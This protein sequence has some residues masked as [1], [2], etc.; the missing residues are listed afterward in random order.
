MPY[1]ILVV[2]DDL[3]VM[4]LIAR[5]LASTSEQYN[6]LK[7]SDGYKAIA[8][9][10]TEQPDLILMDWEMPN[11]DGIEALK[12][13][14]LDEQTREIPV[15]MQ[16]AL[17]SSEKL[18]IAFSSGAVDYIRKPVDK[19]E[20]IA[21]INSALA[22]Y[23]SYRKIK[24]QN[25]VIQHHLDELERLSVIAKETDNSALLLSRDGEIEWVNEGFHRLYE[26]TIEE[27]RQKYGNKI[28]LMSET[29]N[30]DIIFPELCESKKSATFQSVAETKSGDFKWIQTRI[31]PIKD[32]L[33]EIKRFI[34]IEADITKLK[35]DEKELTKRNDGLMRLT[36]YLKELNAIQEK[37]NLEI[38]RA[39]KRIEQEK[40]V[41]EKEKAAL[42]TEKE[43]LEEEKLKTD[44]LLF[45]ILPESVAIQLKSTGSAKPRNYKTAT[46][47][48]TD[49]K[50]FTKICE[51]LTPQQL[52]QILDTYF[53][54]FDDITERH[55]I[56]KIKTIG[57]AYMCVGGVP[58]RNRSNPID[59][60]L[61]G[62]EIQ[63][64]IENLK[65]GNS[66]YDIPAWDLRVG[67][68]TGSVVAGVVGKKKFAYDVWGDAVNIASRME[69]ACEPGR[70]NVSGDTYELI[71]DYFNCI[72]RGKIEA[73][74]KGKVE[75]YFVEGLKPEYAA[76]EELMIPNEYFK[77]ILSTM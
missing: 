73:K 57:D 16:T 12:I 75:M 60:V 36:D 49:F 43:L 7:A 21:R 3:I 56:E 17:V 32:D 77:E 39:K 66:N 26:Y 58:I 71:K 76:D 74:N 24:E 47:L 46:V 23:D 55:Y 1:K 52:V 70:V 69:T 44:K 37:Q 18:H 45:N 9:A 25:R 4:T 14:K 28:F 64:F 11:L 54:A 68:H 29:L 72:S 34:A 63:K 67:V 2:D 31:T 30:P 27:Y 20:L 10:K 42:I 62:L 51:S 35:E 8:T 33:L 41:I 65:N 59:V 50:G 6:V 38:I 15:I 22:L 53:I 61:A 5:M 40:Q 19:I 13:L 48:F